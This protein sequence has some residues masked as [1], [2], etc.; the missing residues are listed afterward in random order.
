M[1]IIRECVVTIHV[2]CWGI[3]QREPRVHGRV[4]AYDQTKQT[5]FPKKKMPTK[6]HWVTIF[7]R[8]KNQI[9][10]HFH[11]NKHAYISLKAMQ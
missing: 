11:E 6:W 10:Y 1:Q 2:L 3:M 5:E 7:D 4:R 9:M 8:K